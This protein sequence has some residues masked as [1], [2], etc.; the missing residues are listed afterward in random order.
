MQIETIR[1]AKLKAISDHIEDPSVKQDL[2]DEANK[3]ILDVD[4]IQCYDK[5]LMNK[6][7]TPWGP[8]DDLEY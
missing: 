2:I 7:G 6:N 3:E 4:E 5:I 8:R 1:A